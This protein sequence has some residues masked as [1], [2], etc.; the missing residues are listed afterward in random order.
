[1]LSQSVSVHCL[2]QFLVTVY[3]VL[4]LLIPFTLMIYAKR[5]PEMS[6]L[7]RVTRRHI[8]EDNILHVF[9]SFKSTPI[10][11]LHSRDSDTSSLSFPRQNVGMS[12]INSAHTLQTSGQV[13]KHDAAAID[14]SAEYQN[15]AN[16]TAPTTIKHG[17]TWLYFYCDNFPR[18]ELPIDT[19]PAVSVTFATM[20]S[21]AWEHFQL[22]MNLVVTVGTSRLIQ[23]FVLIMTY[24]FI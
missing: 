2:L 9:M 11:S 20:V 17:G 8:I 22:H 10:F 16:V 12:W 14:L 4:S 21:I 15:A 3:A 6:V 24:V 7:T 19:S 1:M 18:I 13:A 5:S 23:D